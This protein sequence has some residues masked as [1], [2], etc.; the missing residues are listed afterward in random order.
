MKKMHFLGE[1]FQKKLAKV[2]YYRE[3]EH[4]PY[5]N[6]KDGREMVAM[7]SKH[8]TVTSRMRT[9][10]ER[11]WQHYDIWYTGHTLIKLKHVNSHNSRILISFF[12]LERLKKMCVHGMRLCGILWKS[13]RYLRNRVK[14]G[15][16]K[17]LE[18]T[19]FV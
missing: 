2:K 7:K 9:R 3:R 5:S 13:L 4:A 18:N 19:L 16:F 11:E 14:V 1:F 15:I 12:E 17:A 8:P 10:C 6:V